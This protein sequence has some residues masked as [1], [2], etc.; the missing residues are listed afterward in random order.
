LVKVDYNSENIG[1]DQ[2]YDFKV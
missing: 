1:T 2:K